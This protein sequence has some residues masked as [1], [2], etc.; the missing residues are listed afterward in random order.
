VT[1]PRGSLPIIFT[2]AEEIVIPGSPI[3]AAVD[4]PGGADIEEQSRGSQPLDLIL[5]AA[6]WAVHLPQSLEPGFIKVRASG[7]SISIFQRNRL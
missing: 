4:D 7:A 2:M 3:S 6:S 5:L 1:I